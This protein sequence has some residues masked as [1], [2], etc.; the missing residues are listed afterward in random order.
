MSINKVIQTNIK[1][2]RPERASFI[3]CHGSGGNAEIFIEAFKLFKNEDLKDYAKQIAENAIEEEEKNGGY[4]S[5]YATSKQ[6]NDTS[7]FMGNAGIGYFMLR[8][9]DP[10]KTESILAPK[11]DSVYN[12]NL[13]AGKF[14]NLS[15]DLPSLKKM[16]IEKIFPRTTKLIEQDFSVNLHSY[17]NNHSNTKL[18]L[19]EDF[20]EFIQKNELF[21]KYQAIQEIAMLEWEK[22]RVNAGINSDVLNFVQILHSVNDFKKI[23]ELPESDLLKKKLKLTDGA[24]IITAHINWMENKKIDIKNPLPD[25][26][27]YF[28]LLPSFNGTLEIVLTDLPAALLN[29]FFEVNS[30]ENVLN[31]VLENFKNQAEEVKKTIKES[32]IHNILYALQK[33]MLVVSYQ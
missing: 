23:Q 22:Y 17:F 16:I 5:G 13:N 25:D 2:K 20:Y 12:G 29:S 10:D 18:S 3:L 7:L 28:L 27:Y 30:V 1:N 31:E 19:Q 8:L 4:M 9:H 33:G 21:Q 32:V 14:K 24:K 6:E 11:T 15:V 26:E